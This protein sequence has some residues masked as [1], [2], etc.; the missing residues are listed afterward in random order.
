MNDSLVKTPFKRI[1]KA[2]YLI[3]DGKVMLGPDLPE[4]SG[5]ETTMFRKRNVD[6]SWK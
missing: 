6:L 2:I 5:V 4:L 1:E 3:R